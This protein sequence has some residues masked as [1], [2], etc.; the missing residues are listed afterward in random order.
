MGS[1]HAWVVSSWII[2]QPGGTRNRRSAEANVNYLERTLPNVA[3]NLALDE[4]LLLEAEAGRGGEVLRVW[5]WPTPA[6]VLGCGCKLAADVKEAACVRDGVPVLRRSSGGGTVLLG[7]GCLLFSL[8]LRYDRAP[9]L[10]EIRSSYAYILGQVARAL[11]D[12]AL[13][14]E[15]AGVSD[16]AM[17]GLKFSG[18]AQQRKRHHLLHHGTLLYAFP[19]ETVGTYLTL[20][21]RQPD[22]RQGRDHPSFLCNLPVGRDTLITWLRKAWGADQALAAWPA[23]GVQQLVADKYGSSDW[24]RRR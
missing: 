16:L 19:L 7:S 15:P 3:E 12:Q 22:Y 24:T 8:I 6:V 1:Y 5:Q 10:G 2:D 11:G 17:R 18:N 20:P 13:G 14:I 9:Q 23:D 4:A 21:E